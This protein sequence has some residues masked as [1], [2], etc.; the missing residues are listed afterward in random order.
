MEFC[1]PEKL[2]KMKKI[3]KNFLQYC[4]GKKGEMFKKESE[5]CRGLNPERRPGEKRTAEYNP[6][7]NMTSPHKFFLK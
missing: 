7:N 2:D 1:F 4:R 5:L 3:K 6:A